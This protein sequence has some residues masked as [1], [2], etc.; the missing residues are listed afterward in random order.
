MLKI[1]KK[2]KVVHVVTHIVLYETKLTLSE[3]A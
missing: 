1:K 2:K 3:Q